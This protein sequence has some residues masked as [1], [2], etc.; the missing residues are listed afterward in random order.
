MSKR[1]A[2]LFYTGDWL[3]D[4]A[5]RCCSLSARGMWIDMLCHMHDCE[6]YGHLK[7]NHKVIHIDMLAS[8]V[9][10]NFEDA[11][12][13]IKELIDAGVCH[14]LD[15]GT[16]YSPRMVKDEEIRLKRASG[17]HLGG[18]PKLK[19]KTKKQKKDKVN[20]RPESE[21]EYESEIVYPFN[22]EQFKINWN[23]W[24]RYKL[25]TFEFKYKGLMS[26]QAA[27]KKI[28]ELCN[29]NESTAIAIIH[30]SIEN[31]W[32]GLFKITNNGK[33]SNSEN[34][35]TLNKSAKERLAQY[36][37]GDSNNG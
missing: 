12:R 32:Q 6:P 8:M 18:N 24:K 37:S 13:M 16:F 29:G 28:S 4:T 10:V 15:D 2:F 23:I 11:K 31:Q 19:S 21:S 34:G 33:Q 20:L 26:E 22:S 1:P 35:A 5:L 25:E 30:Q 7:V 27:L 3:K 17:G 14:Q 36:F 9:G